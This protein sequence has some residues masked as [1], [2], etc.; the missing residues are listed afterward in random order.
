[1]N[2]YDHATYLALEINSSKDVLSCKGWRLERELAKQS[3][4]DDKAQA[5]DRSMSTTTF[6]DSAKRIALFRR[7]K[8]VFGG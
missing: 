3:R 5:F 1:M 7:T 4:T 2:Y 6:W 8:N